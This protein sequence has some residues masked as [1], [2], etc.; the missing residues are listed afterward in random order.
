MNDVTSI[1]SQIEKGDPSAADQ[2]LPLVYDE[3]RKLAAL[4]LC[5]EKPGQTLQATSLVHDAYIRLIDTDNVQHWDSR[6]H[7]FAAAAEAMRRILVERARQK[8]SQKGGGGR[9]PL[10][11]YDE[12]LAVDFDNSEALRILIVNEALSA[13]EAVSPRK[14]QIVKLRFFAGLTIVEAAR[15]L[16]IAEPTAKRDWAGARVWIYR[17]LTEPTNK[18]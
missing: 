1:L 10:R 14:A 11:L 17:F 18:T 16:G 5:N 9:K 6:G 12:A 8:R 13:L 3:L 7:F 4:R 15:S 2:L